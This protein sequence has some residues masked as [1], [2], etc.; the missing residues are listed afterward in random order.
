MIRSVPWRHRAQAIRFDAYAFAKPLT[1]SG[2]TEEQARTL[3]RKQADLLG[4]HW[5]TKS[6]IEVL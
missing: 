4:A 1:E 3:A 2:F 6:D 5:A